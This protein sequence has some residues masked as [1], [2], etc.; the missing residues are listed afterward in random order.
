MIRLL[1]L[2]LV[3]FSLLI[4]APVMAPVMA[5]ETPSLKFTVT[6]DGIID[7][8]TLRS[9]KARLRLFGIDAPEIRQACIDANMTP[10]DCG[11]QARDRM[12]SIVPVGTKLT[13][14]YHHNNWDRLVVA[15]KN[16]DRDIAEQ[17]VA[18][19]LAIAYRKYSDNYV[20]A[21]DIARKA[22]RG[23]WAGEFD[24]P[25]DYRRK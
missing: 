12:A 21:E 5:N 23:L 18:E 8:D 17:L 3:S 20:P 25:W 22:K 2:L 15:C 19:G 11:K 4:F 6:I 14:D 16:G 24:A 10:Y 13:C 9:G 1:P 7:G